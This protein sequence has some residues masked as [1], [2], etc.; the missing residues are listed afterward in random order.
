MSRNDFAIIQLLVQ[1]GSDINREADPFGGRTALQEAAR[2]GYTRLVEYLLQR[3]A[4]INA[5]SADIAGFTALQG[6]SIGGHSRIVG[7]LLA[8]GADISAVSRSSG[9][10]AIEVAAANGRLETL[11]ILLSRHPDTEKFEQQR[12][13]AVDLAFEN[14]H[15]EIGRFLMAYRKNIK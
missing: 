7:V 9:Q 2:S 5:P 11:Y 12:R 10:S 15:P 1:H 3:G 6:A 14:G 8:A 4:D 13:R